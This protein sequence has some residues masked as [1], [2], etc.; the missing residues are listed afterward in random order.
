MSLVGEADKPPLRV[1]LPQAAMWTGMYA[2]AGTLIAHHYRE[3]TGHGQ[4]VD[5]SMQAGMLWALANAPA[6]WSVNR[7]NLRRNGNRVVG[8]N[9]V[10][11][12]MRAIYPCKDGYINFIIYGGEAGKRSNEGMVEWMSKTYDAPAWLQQKDWGA[13]NVATCSQAE[14]DA[15]ES[16]FASF[17]SKRTKAE[18]LDASVRYEIIGYPV[19]DARDILHDPQLAARE[20]WQV[21]SDERRVTSDQTSQLRYPGPFAKFSSTVC[22]VRRPA[23]RIGEHNTE[24]FCGELG[25]SHQELEALQ[26]N[27]IV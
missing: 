4:H 17:L 16:E 11:A 8:R 2:T 5:V 24:I 10:G 23:P 6:F 15:L 19:S 14:I 18:F 26:N 25:L 20:F 1:T 7:E 13:F 22:K 3:L 21:T 27:G 9:I 12:F